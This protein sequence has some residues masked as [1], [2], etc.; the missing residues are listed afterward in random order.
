MRNNN[1]ATVSNYFYLDERKVQILYVR[2]RLNCSSLNADLFYNH[3]SGNDMC[4]CGAFE[5]TEHYLLHCNNNM[6][7]RRETIHKI[8]IECTLRKYRMYTM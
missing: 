4:S 7:M 5:T 2:L 3:V 6:T 1:K 8:N